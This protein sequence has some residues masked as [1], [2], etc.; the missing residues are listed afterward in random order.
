MRDTT[1]FPLIG[2]LLF[3]L[4]VA[5]GAAREEEDLDAEAAYQTLIRRLFLSFLLLFTGFG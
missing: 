5:A 4:L 3:L 2:H 1:D